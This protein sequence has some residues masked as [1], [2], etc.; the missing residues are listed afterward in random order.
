MS[1]V[2][3]INSDILQFYFLANLYDKRTQ[4]C[5]PFFASNNF[6][7]WAEIIINAGDYNLNF[8]TRKIFLLA[9]IGVVYF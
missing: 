8:L 7:Y 9:Q 4:D 5:Q 6:H 3:R 2:T 1:K